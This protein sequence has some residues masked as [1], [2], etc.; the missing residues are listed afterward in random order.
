MRKVC[1]NFHFLYNITKKQ[2]K[3]SPPSRGGDCSNNRCFS[4]RRT[5]ASAVGCSQLPTEM[6][7]LQLLFFADNA[8]AKG[9]PRSDS[10]LLVYFL[11]KTEDSLGPVSQS[12]AGKFP[13]FYIRLA[14][15]PAWRLHS[16]GG[17]FR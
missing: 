16:D 6:F 3:E 14:G 10:A 13:P 5:P 2:Q 9:A 8:A 17:L 1:F 12:A 15:R 11:A 4:G 7:V